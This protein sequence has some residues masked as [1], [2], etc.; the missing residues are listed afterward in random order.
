M[1]SIIH[2]STNDIKGG[3]AQ[4]AYRL[5][6]ALHQHGQQ[7]TMCVA[8]KQSI[9]PHVSVLAPQKIADKLRRAYEKGQLACYPNRLV[10]AGP[11]HS[12]R[13][14]YRV[15][16]TARLTDCDIVHLHWVAGL[17]DY[18]TFFAAIPSHVSMVWTLHDM[19][20]LTG[21]CHYSQGCERYNE[22]C[23][24]CPL[25]GSFR[26]RDLSQKIWRGKQNALTTLSSERLHLISPSHWLATAAQASSL[27]GKFPVTVIPHGV[28]VAEFAPRDTAFIRDTLAIPL[29][30]QVVLFVAAW[31]NTRRKG[32]EILR[33][34]LAGLA[35]LPDLWLLSVGQ[36]QPSVDLPIP[37]RHLGYVEN[38]RLL[39]L[40]Y[41]AADLFV[42]PSLQEAFGQT[43]LE[44]MACGTPVIA[45]DVGGVPDLVQHQQ[46]GLLVPPQDP[47]AL[48]AALRQLL[49]DSMTRLEMARRCRQWVLDQFTSDRQLE[50]HLQLYERLKN[51]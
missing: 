7:S 44:A 32:F 13:S 42:L 14:S 10:D 17:V 35:D 5:H 50:Q 11:F 20:P 15:A 1:L 9:D 29:N 21:G 33:Q 39:S 37:H 30:A 31:A 3:A 36:G 45:S 24:T 4:A 8:H 46:T 19:A 41:S 28:N 18:P 34:A 47:A 12:H 40:I 22:Q 23:G 26:D 16:L 51:G 6:T 43:A 49:V 25:L 48:Q 27:L 2:L 38:S